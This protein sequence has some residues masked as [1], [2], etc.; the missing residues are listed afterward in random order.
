MRNDL[1]VSDLRN[2][3]IVIW[4]M[5]GSAASHVEIYTGSSHFASTSVHAV[6]NPEKAMTKIMANSFRGA[7]F[8]QIFRMKGRPQ[9]L[10]RSLR[11]VNRWARFESPYDKFR[12]DLKTKFRNSTTSK[13]GNEGAKHVLMQQLFHEQGCFRAIKF[14]AR[15]RQIMCYPGDDESF[16]GRGVTCCMFAILCYQVAGL[17]NYVT[18]IESNDFDLRVSDKKMTESELKNLVKLM[19]KK[20]NNIDIQAYKRYISKLHSKN[21]Y[22]IDWKSLGEPPM[23]RNGGGRPRSSDYSFLPSLNFWKDSSQPITT[24]DWAQVITPGLMLDAKIANPEDLFR[25]LSFDVSNWRHVGSMAQ[26]NGQ[27][28]SEEEKALYQGQLRAYAE[29]A[30]ARR[31]RY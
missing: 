8:K 30:E 28:P 2:G 13:F 11:Q 18:P 9:H 1:K 21:P 4:K 31:G 14:A 6:N 7:F 25:A 22:D 27:A 23:L 20:P 15:R 24:L 10:R 3:D 26:E 5:E 17:V 12:I 29:K 16:T 19:K